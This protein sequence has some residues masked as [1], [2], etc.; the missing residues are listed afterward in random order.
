MKDR[1]NLLAFMPRN[2]YFNIL[3]RN[4]SRDSL[5]TTPRYFL[6][7]LLSSFFLFFLPSLLPLFENRK[8]RRR[9]RERECG[10]LFSA[11]CEFVRRRDGSIGGS[12]A[13][14]LFKGLPLEK[15]LE[16][17]RIPRYDSQ[18][19]TARESMVT[20][21][22]SRGSRPNYSLLLRSRW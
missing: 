19:D 5:S 9:E 7:L 12:S 14:L 16:Q 20:V 21:P 22:P 13:Q 4:T 2:E 8:I 3:I 1:S 10:I 18:R 17:P 11:R 15:L 6:L